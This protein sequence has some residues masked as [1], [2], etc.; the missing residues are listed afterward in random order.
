MMLE[1]RDQQF[2]SNTR[3]GEFLCIWGSFLMRKRI[4]SC[5]EGIPADGVYRSRESSR[6]ERKFLRVP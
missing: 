5:S 1:G 3:W 4:Y 6:L 2:A